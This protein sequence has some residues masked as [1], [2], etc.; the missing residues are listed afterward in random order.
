MH[1]VA[2]TLIHP[3]PVAPAPGLLAHGSYYKFFQ[4]APDLMSITG[5]DCVR[6]CVNPTFI[7]VLGYSEEELLRGRFI[8]TIH[9][10]D[11]AIALAGIEQLRSGMP[12][13][14][15]TV[16]Y[17]CK[18]GDIRWLAW[19]SVYNPD[20]DDIYS[21]GRDITVLKQAEAEIIAARNAAEAASNAKSRFLAATSHDLRQPVMAI[22][23]FL[24]AL[25]QMPQTPEQADAI[26]G[27]ARSNRSLR[28]IFNTL[29]GIARLDD[30]AYQPRLRA[31]DS[32][33]LFS[34]AEA[35]FTHLFNARGLRFKL[36]FPLRAIP[37]VTD[38]CLLHSIMR[39]L[40][41][42]ALKFCH[43]G[44]VLIAIRRRRTHAL[45]QV[46]DTGIGIAPEALA[47]IFEDYYQVGNEARRLEAGFGLGL[48]IVE[49]QARLLG[50]TV[51]CHS[52]V[53]KGTVLELR[54]P[55]QP[56]PVPAEQV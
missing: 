32:T 45:L 43:T 24:D 23:L 40:V 3:H 51:A 4:A 37:L 15:F 16:R 10:D 1:S 39:N 31:F 41:D 38:A 55:L 18:N 42:N 19:H 7:R 49:R 50:A 21:I 28:D 34:W 6:K 47:H 44:G 25:A 48:S 27:I 17:V 5:M 46:W 33:E 52:R 53:G 9:P 54:L 30:G 11:R 22:S 56:A 2:E 26:N 29:L 14:A 35:E 20:N 36:F 12:E 8:D 13:I